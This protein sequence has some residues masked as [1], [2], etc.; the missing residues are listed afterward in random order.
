M[1]AQSFYV[2]SASKL[3]S[4]YTYNKINALLSGVLFV[5]L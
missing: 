4:A 1:L 2:T 3:I 5:V